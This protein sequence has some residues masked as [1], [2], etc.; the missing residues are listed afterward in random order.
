VQKAE[1]YR[2]HAAECM[3]LLRQVDQEDHR[4]ML[5]QMADTWLKLAEERERHIDRKP[6]T[7][8]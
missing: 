6:N 4:Q 2:K 1:Q 7:A 3:R 8:E 5:L